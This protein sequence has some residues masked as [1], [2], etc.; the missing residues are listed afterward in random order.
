MSFSLSNQGRKGRGSVTDRNM[1][2]PKCE[3]IVVPKKDEY[4]ACKLCD[5][6]WHKQ[7]LPTAVDEDTFQLLKKSEKKTDLN[8]YWYCTKQCDR[9]A[10]K[11]L[12]GMAYLEEEVTKTKE[13]VGMIQN[14]VEKISD[15]NFSEKKTDFYNHRHFQ[16][17]YLTLL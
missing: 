6:V 7:C 4:L 2:C 16:V 1:K 17:L 15:G 14:I 9:A 10:A 3:V 13:K 5:S 8:L 11:F 12:S